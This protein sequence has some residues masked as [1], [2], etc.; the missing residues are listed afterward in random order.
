MYDIEKI[1]SW[2]PVHMSE[3]RRLRKALKTLGVELDLKFLP[4]LSLYAD[5]LSRHRNRNARQWYLGVLDIPDSSGIRT[6]DFDWAVS[7]RTV[8]FMRPPLELQ[9][10]FQV[11][12]ATDSFQ[13]TILVPHRPG[14][15]WYVQL[16]SMAF[17]CR[18][19]RAPDKSAMHGKCWGRWSCLSARPPPPN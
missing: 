5:R 19:I 13:G 8:D 16:E 6:S 7:W 18:S 1:V 17:R 2:S 11:K 14:R 3:L 4:F 9:P 15:M 10:L 12:A